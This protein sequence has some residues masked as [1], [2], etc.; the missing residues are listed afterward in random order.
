M[1]IIWEVPGTI[2]IEGTKAR[3]LSQ[4]EKRTGF[5]WYCYR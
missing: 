3:R 4:E 1:T 2:V 5:R